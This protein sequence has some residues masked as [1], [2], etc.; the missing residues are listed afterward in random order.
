M[1]VLVQVQ[2]G[3]ASALWTPHITPKLQLKSVKSSSCNYYVV[4]MD[5]LDT[6]AAVGR[7]TCTIISTYDLFYTA[8]IYLD[9]FHV[10]IFP[11]APYSCMYVAKCYLCSPHAPSIEC[12]LHT[13][14]DSTPSIQIANAT[15]HCTRLW[16][17]HKVKCSCGHFRSFPQLCLCLSTPGRSFAACDECMALTSG[18]G[19]HTQTPVP[20]AP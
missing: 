1:V 11:F 5:A 7:S 17:W 14:Q 18:R 13:N 2:V 9:S 20:H 6:L 12:A 4:Q 15:R 16:Q 8:V 19:H 3:L 10:W